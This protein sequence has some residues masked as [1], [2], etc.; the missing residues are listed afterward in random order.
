MIYWVMTPRHCELNLV[1]DGADYGW[2]WAY[3][4]QQVDPDFG[5]G[6][7][8]KVQASKPCCTGL[9]HTGPAGHT[10]FQR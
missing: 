6:N 8:D 10:L 2:P 3:D 1:E 9:V 5:V 4:D 7:E